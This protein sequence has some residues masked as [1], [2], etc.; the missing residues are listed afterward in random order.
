MELE[1]GS[2]LGNIDIRYPG[3]AGP[4][5]RVQEALMPGEDIATLVAEASPYLTA[6]ASAYGMKVLEDIRDDAAAGTADLGRRLLQRVFGR[7]EQGE[8]LP[9]PLAKL[10]DTP[11]D[12]DALG[13]LRL[14]MRQQLAA[15]ADMLSDV[16]K[17]LAS[18]AAAAHAP[19]IRSGR[20]TYYAERD[21]TI[22]RSS[23]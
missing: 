7:K 15:H 13:A 5:K 19:T 17:I 20:D 1:F 3:R 12:A 2:F 8:P 14:E 23:D 4:L 11:G 16:L 21:M 6:A 22:H 10:A 9:G 18:G